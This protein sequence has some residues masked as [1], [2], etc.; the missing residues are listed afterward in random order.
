[1]KQTNKNIAGMDKNQLNRFVTENF[2]ERL[3]EIVKKKVNPNVNN[4]RQFA[5]FLD[6]DQAA[7][8]RL[9]SDEHRY[10]T[11]DMIAKAVNKL[12]LNANTLFVE[13]HK[14]EKL[15]RDLN[16]IEQDNSGA[17]NNFG[18]MHGVVVNGGV[19]KKDAVKQ[20]IRLEKIVQKLPKKDRIE[21]TEA[22]SSQDGKLTE[23]DGKLLALKKIIDN[24][25]KALAI[26]EKT[27][28][29]IQSKYINLL[30]KSAR[31]QK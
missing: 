31:A 8:S 3:E 18:N 7:I 9:K 2:L 24:N 26:K 17:A 23:L 25:E 11:L 28:T 4:A 5:Q 30:E 29:E 15:M 16:I 27:L 21:I 12:G 14:N 6:M 10:V 19:L 22:L 1:M 20:K 13:N